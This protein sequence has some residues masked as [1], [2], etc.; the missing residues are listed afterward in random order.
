MAPR[1][2]AMVV[3]GGTGN[4]GSC[5]LKHFHAAET[6]NVTCVTRNPADAR[7]QQMATVFTRVEMAVGDFEDPAGM[8]GILKDASRDGARDVFVFLISTPCLASTGFAFDAAN[9]EKTAKV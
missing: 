4:Q 9:E 3:F 5:V 6:P 7:A 1:E 8:E 2:K